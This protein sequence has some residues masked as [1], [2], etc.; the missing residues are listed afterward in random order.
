VC[1]R[2]ARSDDSYDVTGSSEGGNWAAGEVGRV[3]E[4]VRV[5]VNWTEAR[6]SLCGRELLYAPPNSYLRHCVYSSRAPPSIPTSGAPLRPLPVGGATIGY[7]RPGGAGWRHLQPRGSRTKADG[8]ASLGRWRWRGMAGLALDGL[9][10][11]D[12]GGL[13]VDLDGRG[14]AGGPRDVRHCARGETAGRR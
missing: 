14:G 5:A 13:E 7:R 8:G 12:G 10:A 11:R 3:E 1:W 2:T 4:L 6:S 9:A